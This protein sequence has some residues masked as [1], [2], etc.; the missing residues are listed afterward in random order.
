MKLNDLKFEGGSEVVR[1]SVEVE[2][3][4]VLQKLTGV[5]D[6]HSK[7]VFMFDVSGSMGM[8]IAKTFTDQYQWTPETLTAVRQ[9]VITLL[10][11]INSA[12]GDPAL[13]MLLILDERESKLRAM[14]DVSRNE[15]EPYTFT[16]KDDE[17]LKERIVRVDAVGEFGIQVDWANH[18]KKPP[19]RMEL[20]KTL[21]QSEIKN[22]FKKFPDSRIAVIPFGSYPKVIFN[23]GTPDQLWPLLE[24][25]GEGYSGAGFGTD[26][27]S[28]IAKAMEVCRDKPSP[29]GV[30]HFI[31]VSDGEDGN[32]DHNIPKWIPTLKA[33]GVVFDY[34]H[35]GDSH[36]NSGMVQVCKET[37]G[38]C[39]T[40][41][42]ERDL[43]AKFVE[44]VNRLM[45]PPAK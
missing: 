21:A 24:E 38:E 31:M 11:K 1:Q 40:V 17:E 25:M 20:V 23:D 45:L 37:G 29:V 16:P 32:A 42:S 35:I 28:A 3:T 7:L 43:R 12:M 14:A 44:A 26:M 41:N 9:E 39:V 5:Y 30:H 27:L 19:T 36:R 22:R 8:N 34:I 15:D 13:M 18:D 33:S 6:E 10:G 2:R 4:S